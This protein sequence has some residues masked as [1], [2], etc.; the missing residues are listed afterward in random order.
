[1]VGAL[2]AHLLTLIHRQIT[3]NGESA[4]WS[5]G[6]GRDWIDCSRNLTSS[7]GTLMGMPV[8]AYAAAWF[9]LMFGVLVRGIL[10]GQNRRALHRLLLLASLP[11]VTVTLFYLF[12]SIFILQSI[13]LYCAGLYLVVGLVVMLTIPG[14][15]VDWS[16]VIRG[17]RVAMSWAIPAIA[18]LGA[19]GFEKWSQRPETPLIL[20]PV[21]ASIMESLPRVGPPNA[22]LKIVVFGDFQCS[23]C[24]IAAK[25]VDRFIARHQGEVEMRFVNVPVHQI[26]RLA[27]GESL[28]LSDYLASAVG[29]VME[30]RGLFWDFHT[31]I[32]LSD[33]P[34]G[35]RLLWDTAMKL[36]GTSDMNV[37]KHEVER[38]DVLATV[39]RNAG[40]A[41]RYGFARTPCYII[42]GE[43]VDEPMTPERLEA[44][45]TDAL[46]RA[47]AGARASSTSVRQE[48][49]SQ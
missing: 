33:R 5:C 3:Q 16:R 31:S 7:L 8:S 17:T 21:A 34:V 29:V 36:L 9:V 41:T 47:H 46:R 13:C 20:P 10:Q 27:A 6:G 4:A 23:A 45:L 18:F 43:P 28:P 26:R 49:G 35:E 44:R 25:R 15:E 11:A 38:P 48:S 22:P 24:R 19:L 2:Y 12:V 37:L 14:A 30:K 40:I 1:M 32:F 39:R 42:G